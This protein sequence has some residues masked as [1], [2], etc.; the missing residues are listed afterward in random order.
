[1]ERR[2][3]VPD[4]QLMAEQIVEDMRA[5][6]SALQGLGPDPEELHGQGSSD[7]IGTLASWEQTAKFHGDEIT[8]D[9]LYALIIRLARMAAGRTAD[10][11]G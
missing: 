6:D 10:D 1:M 9:D 11:S 7:V 5:E 8:R 3:W 2:Q 4:V